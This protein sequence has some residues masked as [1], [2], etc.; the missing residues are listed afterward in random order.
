MRLV[1]RQI[2]LGFGRN[3]KSLLAGELRYLLEQVVSAPHIMESVNPDKRTSARKLRQLFLP[4]RNR[5]C[6]ILR[7][8][9]R[10]SRQPKPSPWLFTPVF[11]HASPCLP[12]LI[13]D[14]EVGQP[15]PL[16]Q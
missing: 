3:P 8:L 9:E 16:T 10:R 5:P 6:L 14:A 2:T 7:G 15:S 12:L 4:P 1:P 13:A 11:I